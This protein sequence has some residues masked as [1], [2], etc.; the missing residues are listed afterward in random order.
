MDS[1]SPSARAEPPEGGYCIWL[2]RQTSGGMLSV[3]ARSVQASA[4]I[5]PLIRYCLNFSGNIRI[6]LY[7][8]YLY[9]HETSSHYRTLF[10]GFC[11]HA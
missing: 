4:N 9:Q 5:M 10:R 11:G 6:F 8:G 7:V 3:R 2:I 1:H